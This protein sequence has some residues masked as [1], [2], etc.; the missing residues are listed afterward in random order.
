MDR[1]DIIYQIEQ[2]IDKH[3]EEIGLV[4]KGAI[5]VGI[6]AA[7]KKILDRYFSQA[8]Q[9]CKGEEDKSGCMRMYKIRGLKAQR[10]HILSG[11]VQCKDRDCYEYLDN[12]IAQIEAQ[13][14]KLGG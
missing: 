1:N 5:M 14:A 8:A 9:Y 10:K 11:K 4:A 13:I 6:Y 7:S 12:K 2:R 3:I